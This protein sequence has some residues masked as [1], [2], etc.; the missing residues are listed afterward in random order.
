MI[1]TPAL[2]RTYL[3][4]AEAAQYLGITTRTLAEWRRTGRGPAYVRL[5]GPTSRVRY[6]RADLDRWMRARLHAQTAAERSAVTPW[7]TTSSKE[8][9]EIGVGQ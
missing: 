6:D 4:P 3:S 5:A 7:T 8:H 9:G 2:A 1:H